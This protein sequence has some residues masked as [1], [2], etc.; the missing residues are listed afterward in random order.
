MDR[1]EDRLKLKT[2]LP[3]NSFQQQ[4]SKT[5][6][7]ISKLVSD[8]AP[9]ILKLFPIAVDLYRQYE[10]CLYRHNQKS[11]I[12]EDFVDEDTCNFDRH[13]Q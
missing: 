10:N 1:K 8:V 6:S 4:L 11:E 5:W 2:D 3:E 7:R 13:Q 9:Y 12:A